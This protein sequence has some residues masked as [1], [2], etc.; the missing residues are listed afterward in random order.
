MRWACII[1]GNFHQTSSPNELAVAH[2][3]GKMHGRNHRALDVVV[4]SQVFALLFH[5]DNISYHYG[6][7]LQ[8]AYAI[9][10]LR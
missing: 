7:A 5:N 2:G 10:R 8:E 6:E 1:T 4:V 9:R 3:W